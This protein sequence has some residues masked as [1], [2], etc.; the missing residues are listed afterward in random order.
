[1]GADLG[2]EFFG[3]RKALVALGGRFDAF[4]DFFAECGIDLGELLGGLGQL[5]L[6][7]AGVL[8]GLGHFADLH[9]FGQFL[10][11]HGVDDGEVVGGPLHIGGH[12]FA[13]LQVRSSD[14][15]PR[16]MGC[17]CPAIEVPLRA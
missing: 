13:L 9:L 4:L 8:D 7:L 5:L 3:Q 6:E 14:V 17:G 16:G 15:V 12:L 1:L 11:E 10:L 2:L